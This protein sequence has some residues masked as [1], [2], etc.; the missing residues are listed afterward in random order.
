MQF[1]TTILAL[2]ATAFAAPDL[3]IRGGQCEFGQYACS[4]DG[5]SIK[6]CDISGNWVVSLLTSKSLPAVQTLQ[7]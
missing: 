6:Q 3:S 7:C 5:L 2:A 4:Y 1:T